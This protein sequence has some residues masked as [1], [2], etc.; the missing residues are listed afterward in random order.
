MYKK[1]VL[2]RLQKY[3]K[4]YFKKHAPKLVVV[5]GSV[6]KTGTKYAISTVLGEKLRVRMQDGNH[7]SEFSVPLAILGIKYP[8]NPHSIL[9]WFRV[10]LS[11]RVRI[12]RDNEVDVIVQELGM[13]HPGDIVKFGQY[14]RPDIAVVTAV[15]PEH[16]ENMK[17]IETVAKEE[18]S[19]SAFSGLTIINYDDIDVRF[20][21]LLQSKNVTSYGLSEKAEYRLVANAVSPLENKVGV[22]LTPEW[23]RTPITSQLVGYHNFK[24]VVAAAA[25]AAKLG[26]SAAETAAGITK[27]T[28]LPGRMQILRGANGSVILDDTY[29]SSPLAM[30]AALQTLYDI[31]ASRRIAI[32]GGM[33][34][35]GDYSREGHEIVGQKC[36]SKYLEW[37]ITIGQEAA[38]YIAPIA[39]QKGCRVRAFRT[40]YQAGGFV[41]ALLEKD[42][43]VLV[44][45][46]QNNIY[47]EES[48]KP[49]LSNAEDEKLLVRQTRDWMKR[50]NENLD[51]SEPDNV[52][53]T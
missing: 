43:V 12:K 24:S 47:A 30:L 19:V 26:L 39:E 44:K 22:L 16:M 17:D 38:Q 52:V 3:V 42:T 9:E 45:G 8:K 11:A 31:P 2:W 20:A 13:D 46:S 53:V 27:I 14:L 4:K 40:P 18:L 36:D 37:V 50:K 48:I 41:H 35:L 32:I 25:V 34:E 29:N 49:I 21:S 7:N 5:T 51:Y 6:G 33:N 1:F 28:S 23:G 10:F 15:S